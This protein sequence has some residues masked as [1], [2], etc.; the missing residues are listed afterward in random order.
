MMKKIVLLVFIVL[1]GLNCS[2]V[3][4]EIPARLYN[5]VKL[6]V[7]IEYSAD[8]HS[9]MYLD[10]ARKEAI[11][12]GFQLE[13][14]DARNDRE[15]MGKMLDN[16]VLQ[17]ADAILISHGS[18]DDLIKSV[19]RA[20]RRKI[21]VVAFDCEIPLQ[22]VVK[23]DQDDHKMAELGLNQIVQ[24]THGKAK[25]VQIWVGG[26]APADKR[27]ET[28]RSFMPNHPGI[29]EIE[30]F[31]KVTNNTA[32]QTQVMMKSVLQ[33]Y[34]KGSIDVVWA[35]WDEYAKG[36]ARAIQDAGRNEIKLYGVDVS[37][38]DLAMIQ[39]PGNPWV[40][41]VG[42][43]PE[44]IGSVQVRIAAHIL[45]GEQVPERYSLAPVLITRE[46]LPTDQPASM[47]TLHQYVPGFGE[48][49]DFLPPWMQELK[50]KH[51]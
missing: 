44:A 35:N 9:K 13:I 16:A 23:I 37:D 48:T 2:T 22:D 50:A 45:A 11:S 42:V 26:Y 14:M 15:K 19:G 51:R 39:D 21:P 17:Q 28:F 46:M 4:G 24:D 47:T 38:E 20:L 43:A 1:S 41:T 25:L 3:Y 12:L 6:F 32:L 30:R 27:M 31:G 33:K 18:P 34:P 29:E 10:G 8:T 49:T 7:I 40:A 36:A 5:K